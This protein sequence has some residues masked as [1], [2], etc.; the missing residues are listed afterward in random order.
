[1][2][3][4]KKLGNS[5]FAVDLDDSFFGQYK[6]EVITRL[7]KRPDCENYVKSLLDGKDTEVLDNS[8][9]AIDLFLKFR[10]EHED[11]QNLTGVDGQVPMLEFDEIDN[12]LV[13]VYAFTNAEKKRR[14][15][16]GNIIFSDFQSKDKIVSHG[17]KIYTDIMN[18]RLG[19]TPFLKDIKDVI[20]VFSSYVNEGSSKGM[21]YIG[22]NSNKN[23]I[24][25]FF[26][27]LSASKGKK[28][29]CLSAAETFSKLA[30]S[31]G[32]DQFYKEALDT[33][34]KSD[35][36][37]L[38]NLDGIPTKNCVESI[39]IPFL[40]ARRDQ[41]KITL[42]SCGVDFDDF[43]STIYPKEMRKLVSNSIFSLMDV[44]EC[45]VDHNYF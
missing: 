12:S 37:C 19:L 9:T 36:V 10:E 1:M 20:K 31:Y 21:L 7:K 3:E 45:R 16:V 27:Y 42:A 41:G 8:L 23:Y 5:K 22:D 33:A 15:A 43:L 38:Y 24:L 4:W 14:Y 32:K 13:V 18:Q 34:K 11:I 2:E 39:L 29:S 25:D 40:T 26:S 28:V 17:N 6:K 30:V 35:V 44:V